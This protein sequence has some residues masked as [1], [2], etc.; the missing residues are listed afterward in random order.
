MRVCLACEV[1]ER[2]D[3]KNVQH[4]MI[5]SEFHSVHL[6]LNAFQRC[7]ALLLPGFYSRRAEESLPSDPRQ[8][9]NSSDSMKPVCKNAYN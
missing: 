6:E 9:S 8:K 1:C 3:A 2:T 7:F 5:N 4:V